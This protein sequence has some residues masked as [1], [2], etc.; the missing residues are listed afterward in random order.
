VIVLSPEFAFRVPAEGAVQF[1]RES[2][3]GGSFAHKLESKFV[4]GRVPFGPRDAVH[5]QR[6][7]DVPAAK[8][9]LLQNLIKDSEGFMSRNF[10]RAISLNITRLVIDTPI[11]P[12]W[13]TLISVSI[14]VLGGLMMAVPE[15]SMVVTG[16]IL[17]WVH[18]VLD[19]CDGEIARLKFLQSRWGGILDFWS[20]NIVHCVVFLGI[21]FGWSGALEESYPLVLGAWAVA[22]TLL[23]AGLVY[24]RDMANR[25][26]SGPMFTTV[27]KKG[28]A[29]G[30]PGFF[31]KAVDLLSPRDFIYLVIFLAV[32]G[33]IGLFLWMGAVGAPC[34]FLF[35]VFLELKNRKTAGALRRSG[36]ETK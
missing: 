22:G 8:K 7:S 23:S 4:L 13:M 29:S 18:S 2:S 28:P 30:A 36:T 24:F 25:S 14:G 9:W 15:K 20:D 21:A 31:Q 1:F 27:I 5:L 26:G 10:E 33:K 6:E 12:N 34:Y 16:A 3:P 19:G 11:T 32:F 35:L 17:F